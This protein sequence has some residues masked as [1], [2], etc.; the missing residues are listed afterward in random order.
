M[1]SCSANNLG[2]LACHD[3]LDRHPGPTELSFPFSAF[4]A[5][6]V[7]PAALLPHHLAVARYLEAFLGPFVR[8]L[9]GHDFL[10]SA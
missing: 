7:P 5:Q 8:F 2:D 9:F 10:A 1:G 3:A 4:M 6:E